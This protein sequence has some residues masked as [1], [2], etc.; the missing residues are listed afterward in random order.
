MEQLRVLGEQAGV[1]T[2]PDRRRAKAPL[3]IARRAHGGGQGRR[4]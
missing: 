4:L 1:A 3:D 2:L